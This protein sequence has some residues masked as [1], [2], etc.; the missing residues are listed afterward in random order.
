MSVRNA[1]NLFITLIYGTVRVKTPPDEAENLKLETRSSTF[2][3]VGLYVKDKQKVEPGEVLTEFPGPPKW[4][5]CDKKGEIPMDAVTEYVFSVGPFKI[6]GVYGRYAVIWGNNIIDNEDYTGPCR[7]HLINS[8]H[9]RLK[10]P[11][12]V[13]NCVYGVYY[14]NFILDITIPPDITLYAIASSTVTGG[15]GPNP[16]YELRSEYHWCLAF[17]FGYWCLDQTCTECIYALRDFV[18]RVLKE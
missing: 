5:K 12:N 15:N 7:G 17:H 13:T 14:N 6:P 8:S 11:R 3:G 1:S 10:H 4:I 2:N 9:P 16:L 18:N